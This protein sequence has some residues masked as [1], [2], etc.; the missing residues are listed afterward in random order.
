MFRLVVITLLC[1]VTA[2]TGYAQG[3]LKR[4]IGKDS[5]AV[6]SAAKGTPMNTEFFVTRIGGQHLALMQAILDRGVS[7]NDYNTLQ[8]AKKAAI[9]SGWTLVIPPNYPA[10]SSLVLNPEDSVLTVFDFRNGKMTINNYVHVFHNRVGIGVQSPKQVF[11]I[12][13]GMKFGTTA[14]AEVG[15]V[16]WSGTD[17]EVYKENK[18]VSLTADTV[19]QGGTI[20]VVYAANFASLQD[21][22]DYAATYFPNGAKVVLDAGTF[23]LTTTLQNVYSNLTIS[24]LGAASIIEINNST[25]DG[26]LLN[27]VQDVL[28][29]N[30]RLR[31][32]ASP[33]QSNGINISGTSTGC[34]IK[35]VIIE[36]FGGY[37]IIEQTP[38]TQNL[39]IGNDL[40][41][42]GMGALS[43]DAN[44]GTIYGLNLT[45]S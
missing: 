45:G 11:E 14:N 41:G 36:D 28:L 26:I 15:V 3:H 12:A 30:F 24:G 19:I 21:A 31:N 42:N 17:L 5:A 4:F 8:E 29:E 25:A 38:A 33:N 40:R 22:V 32:V 10:D 16:R 18:W 2:G 27:N 34:L 20:G 9:D 23:A 7:A 1:I 39:I 43:I 35:G 37:G 44:S 6:A 13:G